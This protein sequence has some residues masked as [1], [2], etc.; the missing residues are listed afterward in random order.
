MILEYAFLISFFSILFIAAWI[1]IRHPFWSIQP[2]FHTYDIWRYWIIHP[3]VIST[4]PVPHNKFLN[5]VKVKTRDFLD[6]SDNE[7]ANVLDVIQCHYLPSDQVTFTLSAKNLQTLCTNHSSGPCWMSMYM[8]DHFHVKE[9]STVVNVPE[10]AGVLIAYPVRMFLRCAIQSLSFQP[11]YYWD[12]IVMHRETGLD[13]GTIRTLLQSHEANQRQSTPNI[14][15]SIFRKEVELSQG[16]VPLVKFTLSQF[17]LIKERI[18]R[19]PLSHAVQCTKVRT[20][21]MNGLFDFLFELSTQKDLF[22]VCLFPDLTALEARIQAN[23]WHIYTLQSRDHILAVYVFRNTHIMYEEGG[24][25]LE[26]MVS[27]SFIQDEDQ[28]KWFFAGWLHALYD[29][30]QLKESSKS[31]LSITNLGHNDQLLK[32]YTWKYKSFNTH[33]AAYY[34]YNYVCPGM[35][36][37]PDRCWIAL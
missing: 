14:P 21:T 24:E 13:V 2:V 31:R 35:P 37:S 16:I 30:L 6:A 1:R 15:S 27:V 4:M 34:F 28:Q 10:V 5:R 8:T 36:L 12:F 22:D 18:Q 25:L 11:I 7:F 23:E 20:E 9:D 17:E 3:S 19:P 26:C 29:L 32:T 33:D